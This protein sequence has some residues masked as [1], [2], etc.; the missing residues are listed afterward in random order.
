MAYVVIDA[1]GPSPSGYS[2][3]TTGGKSLRTTDVWTALASL[4]VEKVVDDPPHIVVG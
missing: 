2:Y 1:I 3:E 4:G